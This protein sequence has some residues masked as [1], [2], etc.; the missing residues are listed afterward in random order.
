MV[1][2][3]IRELDIKKKAASIKNL[4]VERFCSLPDSGD[5]SASTMVLP[6]VIFL[7]VIRIRRQGDSVV[8]SKL[9]IGPA[10]YFRSLADDRPPSRNSMTLTFIPRS[11]CGI[12]HGINIITF[13][14]LAAR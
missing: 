8:V 9:V 14:G 10:D 7:E 6:S 1:V 11:S 3:L 12:E 13:S 2:P 5:V 4:N